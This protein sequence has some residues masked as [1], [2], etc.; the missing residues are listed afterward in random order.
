MIYLAYGCDSSKAAER[1][2]TIRNSIINR[3]LTSLFIE[4]AS[5]CNLR[6]KFCDFHSNDDE[7]FIKQK[8]IMSMETFNLAMDNVRSLP[9][10]F[11]VVYFNLHGE[12][13][14][15]ANISNMIRKAKEHNIADRHSISTN[16]ILLTNTKLNELIEAGIDSIIVSLDTARLQKYKS[17]KG[18]DKLDV[19]LDN[20][21]NAIE[22]I[23]SNTREI[24][25][26]IKC[27]I[28]AGCY[29]ISEEDTES[30]LLLYKKHAENSKKIHIYFLNEFKW[31]TKGKQTSLHADNRLC[32]LLF[33]QAAI[34]YDGSV[35]CCCID[36]NHD[37]K[38]G[39]LSNRHSLRDILLSEKLKY[40]RKTH[41]SGNLDS[42]PAC[43]FC[44]NRPAT[45]LADY[46]EEILRLL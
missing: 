32:D 12:P 8:G 5:A 42:L 38:L 11:K 7:N 17:F 1:A 39:T 22:V 3:E 4:P 13:L 45:D 43:K 40:L 9:F 36:I 21:S 25:L 29:G 24:S 33:Y 20:I 46:K 35:S 23:S 15:N 18:S 30:V 26:Q 14:L 6:C 41:L 34:H 27:T 16:G 10:K 2:V 31:Y 19:V 28:Q 44:E 37:L